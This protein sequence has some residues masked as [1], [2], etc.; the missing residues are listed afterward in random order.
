MT[1][2]KIINNILEVERKGDESSVTDFRRML[3]MF[4]EF[5]E[6]LKVDIQYQLNESL[7]KMD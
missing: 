4:I 2:Q 5:V 6:L 3:R 1:P 7:K